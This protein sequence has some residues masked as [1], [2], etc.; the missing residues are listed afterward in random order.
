MSLPPSQKKQNQ[1]ELPKKKKVLKSLLESKPV[2]NIW[3]SLITTSLG[4]VI[5]LGSLF[6][7]IAMNN[8][9]SDSVWGIAVGLGLLFAPDEILK[10]LK[11]FIK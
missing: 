1:T 6:S 3:K 2:T 4:V 11:N 8:S 7:S 5:I 10:K 9:W